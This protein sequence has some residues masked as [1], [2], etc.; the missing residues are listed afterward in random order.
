[1]IKQTLKFAGIFLTVLCLTGSFTTRSAYAADGDAP[2]EH[3]NHE[4]MQNMD[5]GDM[6]K[7]HVHKEPT[8]QE[9]SNV[10]VTEHL[11][12]IIPLD[13]EF[14]TS[15]GRTVTLKE[16]VDKPTLFAPVYY[17]CPNVCNFLQSRLADII[18]QMKMKVGET[19]QVVS[20]SFDEYDTP[21]TAAEKK[22]NYMKAANGAIPDNGWIFLTGS[23]ENID[24]LMNALGFR[25]QRKDRDFLHPVSVMAVSRSGKIVRYLYG[26]DI[27]PFEMT[28]SVVEAEKETPGL[29]VKK[30][31]AYCFSYDPQGKKYVFDVMKVSGIVVLLVIAVFASYLFFGGKKR[32]KRGSHEQ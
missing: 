20:V 26:T 28:M 24:K 27:L 32:K 2:A 19:F 12:S 6:A 4:D 3:M 29:S 8:P 7:E 9:Q 10:G 16:I 1:M 21:K 25:F 23:K 22:V 31:V 11:G 5:H 30:L 14:Q 13:L 17:S 15:D 18:P